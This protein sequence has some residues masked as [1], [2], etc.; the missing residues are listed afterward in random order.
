MVRIV[1]RVTVVVVVIA[2]VLLVVDDV[3]SFA[4]QRVGVDRRRLDRLLDVVPLESQ[5][6]LAGSLLFK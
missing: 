4:G 3:D 5:I 6:V 2:G 1:G